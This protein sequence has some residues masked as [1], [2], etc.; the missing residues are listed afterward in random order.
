MSRIAT[1]GTSSCATIAINGFK[2]KDKQ[3]NE[4]YLADP[5]KVTKG[6]G[7]SVAEFYSRV[8]YPTSQPLDHT[9]DYPFELLMKELE[10]SSMVT[11]FTIVTLNEYQIQDGYWQKQLEKWGF[12]LV[13]K[14]KNTIGS[15]NYIFTRNKNRPADFVDVKAA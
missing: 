15:M 12:N 1:M 3:L 7:L 9:A 14:T 8:L 6:A 11:K 4:A 2:P 5:T 10:K 13:D